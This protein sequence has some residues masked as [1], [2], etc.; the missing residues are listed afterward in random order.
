VSPSDVNAQIQISA[1]NAVTPAQAQASNVSTLAITA[2][3]NNIFELQ[4]KETGGASTFSNRTITVIPL[5]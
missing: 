3:S 1:S 5:N 2:G 4:Y